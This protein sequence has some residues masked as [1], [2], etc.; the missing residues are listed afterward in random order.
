MR[1]HTALNPD[2]EPTLQRGVAG[3]AKDRQ[4]VMLEDD[5]GPRL[6]DMVRNIE[7]ATCL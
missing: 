4:F 5:V 3:Q 1:R 6:V 2:L 7:A